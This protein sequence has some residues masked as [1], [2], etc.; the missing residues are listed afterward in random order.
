MQA[1]KAV[2]DLDALPGCGTY[3]LL[4]PNSRIEHYKEHGKW[5]QVTHFYSEQL[6]QGDNQA[7][8]ELLKSFKKSGL[9]HI[10]LLCT[11]ETEEPQYECL[12][13]LSQW[14]VTGNERISC[15]N[16]L[17][18]ES[19]EKYR[20]YSLKSLHDNNICSF[21]D[22][23]KWQNICLVENLKHKSFESSHNLYPVLTH[24]QSLVEM[25]DFAEACSTQDFLTLLRKWEVQ[26]KLLQGS[27]FQ[28]IDSII[29]QRLVMLT[30]YLKK[31][32]RNEVKNYI[33]NLSLDFA[34][35]SY[36]LTTSFLLN[37]RES[38]FLQYT[39]IVEV[40]SIK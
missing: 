23:Y 17:N 9:Y 6:F 36:I 34:G 2:G 11:K 35:W 14:D 1:Y 19:Y 15:D 24:L 3:F 16:T 40:K 13:R 33:I 38:L 37:L 30:D 10:P 39:S 27:N 22:G 26:D 25:E 20:F 5:D 28:Y 31:Q 18:L 32:N 12:W 29:S 21:K 4:K 7:K 8:H